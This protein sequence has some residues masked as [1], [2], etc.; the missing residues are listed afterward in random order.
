MPSVLAVAVDKRRVEDSS[1]S[2]SPDLHVLRFDTCVIEP[3]DNSDITTGCSP[4]RL[5]VLTSLFFLYDGSSKSLKFATTNSQPGV[6]FVTNTVYITCKM[7]GYLVL[8]SFLSICFE[9]PLIIILN[10]WS[11]IGVL[12]L[13]R[14]A[15]GSE[16]VPV[17]ACLSPPAACAALGNSRDGLAG[18]IF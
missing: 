11:S 14:P 12:L 9:F 7:E 10:R 13:P 15:E 6:C 17:R 5:F 4:S 2:G 3:T 8:H 1:L 18:V 16:Q